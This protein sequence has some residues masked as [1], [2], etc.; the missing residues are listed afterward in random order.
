MKIGRKVKDEFQNNE[1]RSFPYNLLYIA[2]TIKVVKN[3]DGTTLNQFRPDH[4]TLATPL[5]IPTTGCDYSSKSEGVI[6]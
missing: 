5:L 1:T 2:A 3:S 6:R 4:V